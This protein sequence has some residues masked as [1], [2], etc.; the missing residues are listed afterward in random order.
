M[1]CHLL[2][3]LA[4]AAAT[5]ATSPASAAPAC[6]S[7]ATTMCLF[8]ADVENAADLL[9]RHFGVNAI[10]LGSHEVRF[11]GAFPATK[12]TDAFGEVSSRALMKKHPTRAPSSR[13]PATAR[14]STP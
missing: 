3:A 11:D 2:A 7:S 14:P 1:K 8:D 4:L 9:A 10:V 12:A 6:A 13:C 5:A